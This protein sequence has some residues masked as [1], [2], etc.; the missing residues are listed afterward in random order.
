MREETA[1][2]VLKGRKLFRIGRN[3]PLIGH[4]AFGIIDRGTNLLQV[5]P[6]SLCP[7]SCV[8][9]SVDAG[10]Y[11]LRRM[12]EYIVEL[13]H[14]VE[15]VKWSINIKELERAQI[16]IDSAGDP[17]TYPHIVRLVSK[18]RSV[19]SIDV[20]SLETRGALLTEELAEKLDEAGL[21]RINLSIDSLDPTLAKHL[22]G[23][24]WYDV[25]KVMKI[26]RYIASNL[27]MDL[28]ITPVWIPGVN[29]K[30][31]PRIIEFAL[32]IGAGKKWPPLG[33]QK[34]EAHKHGRKPKGVK[35]LTW[36]LFYNKLRG[37]EKEYGVKLI[38]SPKDFGIVR[39]KAIPKVY[40]RGERASVIVAGPGW[41]KG[42]CIAV[43]KG[44]VI[45]V[46]GVKGEL[47]IGKKIKV[48]VL[49]NKD[50]IYVAEPIY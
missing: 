9:C 29:D 33:I 13:E 21:S 15:W 5:R 40:R 44:R 41:L 48:R 19:K 36:Y 38:L 22:S 18:L 43:G 50:N 28:I 45:T 31:I 27:R 11:S 42:Q 8:F 23:T 34:Y 14:L 1:K 25:E 7:L 39:A 32:N 6:S 10:P 46:V 35:P 47:D 17:L 2:A 30:E 3:L 49:R 16:H 26:A 12:T 24:P 20:I 37:W 4:I